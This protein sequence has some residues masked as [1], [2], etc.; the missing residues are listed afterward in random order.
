M[1]RAVHRHPFDAVV[2]DDDAVVVAARSVR[3]AQHVGLGERAVGWAP[4]DE[5]ARRTVA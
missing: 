4:G 3:L 5:A 1:E 2:G